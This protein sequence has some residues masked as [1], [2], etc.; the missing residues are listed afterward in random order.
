MASCAFARKLIGNMMK[1]KNNHQLKLED[2][3]VDMIER[4][5]MGVDLDKELPDEV[6]G[7]E[8]L[9]QIVS[10]SWN[11]LDVD[12]F[13]Y[14]ARD[15]F[16]MNNSAS[17][18]FSIKRMLDLSRVIKGHICFKEKVADSLFSDIFVPRINL[19]RQIYGHRVAVSLDLMVGEMI[20]AFDHGQTNQELKISEL[21]RFDDKKET[22]LD[23]DEEEFLKRYSRLIDQVLLADIRFAIGEEFEKAQ[24]LLN[25]IYSRDLYKLAGCIPLVDLPEDKAECSQAVENKKKVLKGIF[26]NKGLDEQIILHVQKYNY[27]MGSKNPMEKVYC[28]AESNPSVYYPYDI[29][30]EQALFPSKFEKTVVNI[31]VRERKYLEKASSIILS[32]D[33]ADKGFKGKVSPYKSPVADLH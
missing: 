8:F 26:K 28:Y 29:E 24:R 22:L 14:L 19:H 13:D 4:M 33:V 10:N 2:K 18:T 6:K 30:N 16:Y 21:F 27:G 25:R 11:S 32:K 31:F 23:R 9:Y 15:T 20:E 1:D 3:H 17:A 7:R 5:I 12:K